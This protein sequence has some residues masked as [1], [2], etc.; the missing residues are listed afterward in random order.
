MDN[1]VKFKKRVCPE[2]YEN[3]PVKIYTREEIEEWERNIDPKIAMKLD[4]QKGLSRSDLEFLDYLSTT[5]ADESMD[6]IMSG[7]I[8]GRDVKHKGFIA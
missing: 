5:Q 6:D 8:E 2:W 1:L 7:V 4:A 3:G